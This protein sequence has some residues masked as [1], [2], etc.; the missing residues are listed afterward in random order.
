MKNMKKEWNG[1]WWEGK[2]GRNKVGEWYGSSG[3]NQSKIKCI[4]IFRW[5]LLVSLSNYFISIFH[6]HAVQS[7]SSRPWG[8]FLS[9]P[10]H[11]YFIAFTLVP[12]WLSTPCSRLS[13]TGSLPYTFCPFETVLHISLTPPSPTV[14]RHVLCIRRN[15][16]TCV[17]SVSAR[18]CLRSKVHC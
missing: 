14:S 16:P 8:K 17:Q 1:N 11:H 9:L 2:N 15:C 6:L 18:V 7:K 10:P 4:Y 3:A 12:L 5:A 13:F